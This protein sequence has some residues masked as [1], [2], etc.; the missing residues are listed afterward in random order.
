MLRTLQRSRHT[1]PN[2]VWS[3]AREMTCRTLG[4]DCPDTNYL[5]GRDSERAVEH[6]VYEG[7]LLIEQ[8][9]SAD[10]PEPREQF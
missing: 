5:D 4:S 9:S 3:E 2:L 8:C 10:G 6:M 7:E 1:N